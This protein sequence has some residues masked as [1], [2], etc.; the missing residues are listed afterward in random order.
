MVRPRCRRCQ[1]VACTSSAVYFAST[2]SLIIIIWEWSLRVWKSCL[3]ILKRS[4]ELCE[5]PSSSRLPDHITDGYT[6]TRTSIHP[7]SASH[8]FQK[9]QRSLSPP[10]LRSRP[11]FRPRRHYFQRRCHFPPPRRLNPTF[12]VSPRGACSACACRSMLCV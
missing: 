3:L 4:H 1:H 7:I 8:H 9:D 6:Y 11:F 10:G 12:F 2:M 5:F